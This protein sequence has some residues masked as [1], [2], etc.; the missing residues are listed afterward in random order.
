MLCK[1]IFFCIL[2]M[3]LH[4]ITIEIEAIKYSNVTNIAKCMLLKD[5]EFYLRNVFNN[6][7]LS[8]PTSYFEIN[9]NFNF[10]KTLCQFAKM[11]PE[12]TDSLF[13]GTDF[14]QDTDRQTMQRVC[15]QMRISLP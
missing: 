1:T 11:S 2:Y 8:M 6:P 4:I 13:I 7:L 9:F 15:K 12:H 3:Y 5:A 14:P 10:S